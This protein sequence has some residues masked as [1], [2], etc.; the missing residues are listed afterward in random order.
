LHPT[1]SQHRV[2]PDDADATVPSALARVHPGRLPRPWWNA[3]PSLSGPAR[4]PGDV[5]S[6]GI[7]ASGDPGTGM[8]SPV[9]GL[10]PAPTPFPATDRGPLTGLTTHGVR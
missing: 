1:V 10:H 8:I 4:T 7:P 9:L 6:F 5:A 3:S 2:I